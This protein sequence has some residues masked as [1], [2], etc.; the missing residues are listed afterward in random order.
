[1]TWGTRT[2][3]NKFNQTS[4][5]LSLATRLKRPV[6]TSLLRNLT[7][8]M[9]VLF[10]AACGKQPS[11]IQK[12]AVER[13]ILGCL[14]SVNETL[15]GEPDGL[16]GVLQM[17]SNMP[18]PDGIKDRKW[19]LDENQSLISLS[20]D[21]NETKYNCDY[22]PD[23]SGKMNIERVARNDEEVFNRK[24][25]DG[26]KLEKER[27][28]EIERQ[29]KERLAEIERQET[30]G[31]WEEK[32]FSNVSYNYFQKRHRSSQL[33]SS[34]PLI[35][36]L[37]DP[38]GLRVEYESGSFSLNATRGKEFR[39]ISGT[40]KTEVNFDLDS[41][42]HVGK[43][44]ANSIGG[45]VYRSVGET[46]R[47]LDL[48][49]NATTVVIDGFEFDSDNLSEVPCLATR[50]EDLAIKETRFK[51][52]L[53]SLEQN[54]N[55]VKKDDVTRETSYIF[56][57]PPSTQQEQIF[58]EVGS[59]IIANVEHDSLKPFADEPVKIQMVVMQY[60]KS[61]KRLDELD[62]T[63]ISSG[64]KLEMS[65]NCQYDFSKSI[66]SKYNLAWEQCVVSKLPADAELIKLSK[67]KDVVIQL[68]TDQG[69][70]DSKSATTDQKNFIDAFLRIANQV[71]KF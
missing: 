45:D 67:N 26:I 55:E 61:E 16:D 1:M 5:A 63:V 10:L 2:D 44:K 53:Q 49:E 52:Y 33:G 15:E 11:E 66:S 28:A 13:E 62:L 21:L 64:Q 22:L 70:I 6:K 54:A 4:K 57:Y 56:Q 68:R 69:T 59:M 31:T 46:H 38:E 9:L 20:F 12:A 29:E 42:G 41:S 17:L 19:K 48:L 43:W 18:S 35:K 32:S 71:S 23:E 8:G 60:V 30:I 58:G 47:F 36:V 50:S 37:C 25:N 14:L 34:E 51:Q 40:D 27:L 7:L 65:F 39:F 24:I 3:L